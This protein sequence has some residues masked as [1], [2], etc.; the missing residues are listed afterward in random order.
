MTLTPLLIGALVAVYFAIQALDASKDAE[1]AR[2]GFN[3]YAITQAMNEFSGNV[4]IAVLAVLLGG[5]VSLLV[6][7]GP[8]GVEQIRSFMAPRVKVVQE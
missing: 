7:I 4:L 8:E 1:E 5:G 2:K 6:H 3:P